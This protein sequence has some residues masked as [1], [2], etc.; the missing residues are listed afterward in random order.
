MSSNVFNVVHLPRRDVNC[1]IHTKKHALTG[2]IAAVYGLHS[3]K[4]SS[5][6]KPELKLMIEDGLCSKLEHA[7]QC[8]VDRSTEFEESLYIILEK[9]IAKRHTR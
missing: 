9:A 6:E 1:V 7:F 2:D 8:H 5:Q 3:R 4:K